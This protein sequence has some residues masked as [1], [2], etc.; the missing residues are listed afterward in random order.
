MGWFVDTYNIKKKGNLIKLEIKDS[1]KFELFCIF[2][3]ILAV[4]GFLMTV[5][6]VFFYNGH[7]K[8]SALISVILILIILYL[9]HLLRNSFSKEIFVL[10]PGK[11]EYNTE[12]KWWKIR[13]SQIYYFSEIE[14]YYDSVNDD[15][16]IES[17]E[18]DIE[19]IKGN[20]TVRFYMDAGENVID[21]KGIIP[22][23]AIQIIK[24]EYL[25]IKKR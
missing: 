25:Y 21:S 4:I 12:N 22:I 13:T 14:F 17:T 11:L 5:S 20:Y 3:L 23:E 18:L 10:Y 1:G 6:S 19:Q 2:L 7:L 9:L 24:K 16:E 8:M 15:N